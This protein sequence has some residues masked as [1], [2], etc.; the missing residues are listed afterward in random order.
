MAIIFRTDGAW[1]AGKGSNLLPAEVDENF[2]DIVQ[3][4]DAIEGS[5]PEAVSIASFEQVGT[6]LTITMTDSS[7]HG[8]FTLPSARFR[9]TGQ[10]MPETLYFVNDIFS[11]NGA[12]YGVLVQHISE[13]AFDPERFD[14]A[15]FTYLLML[16]RP[17][18][19]YDVGLFYADHIPGDGRVLLQHIVARQFF[20]ASEYVKSI[21]YLTNITTNVIELPIY[22]N[23]E[24]I[25]SIVFDPSE[26]AISG[27]DG[28][29]GT[30]VP[31][32]PAETLT[33]NRGDRLRVFAPEDGADPTALG[34][35]VTFVGEA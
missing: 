26:G 16:E 29:L 20:I 8:P 17:T 33:F 9:F 21:A 1:G 23:D 27:E 22:R 24:F 19:P 7:S 30:F 34:L 5:P 35:A 31:N 6:Q 10:Y 2:W 28:Q 4:L 12:L 14:D 13:I 11:K 25:G 3:R 15:G 18:Q 32:S